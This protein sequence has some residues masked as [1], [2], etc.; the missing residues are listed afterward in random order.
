MPVAFD[1]SKPAARIQDGQSKPPVA[2][3]LSAG[4]RGAERVAHAAG[5]DAAIDEAVEEAILRALKSPAVRRAIDRAVEDQALASD[6]RAEEISRVV[7]QVLA[8]EAA[9]QAWKEVL[10]SDQV[11]MLV[12]RIAEAPEV[13]AAITAQGAG[14]VTDIGV[15][16]THL[17][18]TLDDAVER[19]V[20]HRAPDCE[21]DQAGL[22]TRL[23][24]AGV[25]F[26]LAFVV[27]A[28]ASSMVSALVPVASGGKISIV[29]IAVLSA[30][31]GAAT[32]SVIVAF[33]ALVGQTPGMR[34][35]SIRIIRGDSHEI[36]LRCAVRRLIGVALAL[37]PAGL[38]I[39]AIARNSERRGWHDRFAGTEVVYDRIK[40]TAPYSR[41]RNAGESTRRRAD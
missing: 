39:L 19:I 10:A 33:W 36:G 29:L 8:S 38:G 23:A 11:Q 22:I 30:V 25:D 41:Q 4:A 6:L 20:R 3:L 1:P 5:L 27:Y 21:T 9:A 32:L 16:L 37:I 40:R 12:E 2:R 13:R 18:E 14:L 17:T 24:A 15:R 28:L 34:F 26:G 35:L 31:G 7:R